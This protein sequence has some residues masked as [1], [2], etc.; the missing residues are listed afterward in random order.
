MKKIFLTATIFLL[1]SCNQTYK[2][3]SSYLSG[4]TFEE[5]GYA[6]N[7]LSPEDI[8]AN[9]D[10]AKTHLTSLASIEF[11]NKKDVNVSYWNYSQGTISSSGTYTIKNN[12]II[13]S[14][15]KLGVMFGSSCKLEN[16][17]TLISNGQFKN[18]ELKK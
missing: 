9:P 11:V 15:K 3:S 2:V 18:F 1:I 16:A 10:F 12:T 14:L 8:K 17:E 4:K 7:Q 5:K 6:E 13:M